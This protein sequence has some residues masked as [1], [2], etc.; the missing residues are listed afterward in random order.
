MR[1]LPI[2]RSRLDSRVVSC[3]F[4]DFSLSQSALDGVEASMPQGAK[5]TSRSRRGSGEPE[6]K[7]GGDGDRDGRRRRSSDD[8]AILSSPFFSL[9]FLAR[10][11]FR[12]VELAVKTRNRRKR[13]RTESGQGH[14]R[15]RARPIGSLPSRE[16]TIDDGSRGAKRGKSKT[17]SRLPL[18]RA[19]RG[20]L[21]RR[22][23]GQ[24]E[25]VHVSLAAYLNHCSELLAGTRGKS[26]STEFAGEES[27]RA[28]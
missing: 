19:R 9:R 24:E 14:E 21:A 20:S 18:S 5:E 10:F 16:S 22:A 6:R 8:H 12:S 25:N 26:S 27:E 2:S 4:F 13:S 7:G 3:C 17:E 11:V 28:S 23:K 1:R 15:E